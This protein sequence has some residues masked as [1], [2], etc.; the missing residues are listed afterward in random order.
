[1]FGL[2]HFWAIELVV[3]LRKAA[4]RDH[5]V[6][7]EILPTK[8]VNKFVDNLKVRCGGPVIWRLMKYPVNPMNKLSLG[9]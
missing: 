6:G 9:L 7:S 8:S 1:M 4:Y 2:A 5:K 3:N